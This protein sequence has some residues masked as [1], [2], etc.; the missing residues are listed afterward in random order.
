MTQVS[1]TIDPAAIVARPNPALPPE[2]RRAPVV[3]FLVHHTTANLLS[4]IAE[5]SKTAL[6]CSGSGQT[7]IRNSM[8]SFRWQ[9]ARGF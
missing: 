3:L 4:E 2:L 6:R 7:A 8:V 5:A 9:D 1:V